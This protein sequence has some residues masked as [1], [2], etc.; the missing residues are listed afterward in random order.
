MSN[1]PSRSALAAALAIALGA[2]TTLAAAATNSLVAAE[3]S[4]AAI[5]SARANPH[6]LIL[7]AG[8]FDPATQ[9]LDVSQVGAAA[10]TS[11]SAYAIVQFQPGQISERKALAARG[12]TFLG[13]V[14]NQAYYARLDG[15]SLSELQRDPAVRWA[16]SVQPAMKLDPRL[17]ATQRAN[18]A[19][20]QDDGR[21]EVIIHGFNGVS[22]AKIQAQLLQQ[23]AGVEIT[24]RSQRDAATPYV[25]AR[26]AADSLDALLRAATA[27]DGVQFVMPWYPT[28][29]MNAGSIGAIQGDATTS[30]D[31][32]G[33]ICGPAPLFD[34][35]IVGA[36]QIIAIADTGTT[37][38]AAWFATLDKGNGPHTEVTFSDNPPPV[39]PNIG[40]LHP[41]NKII[42]YWLQPGG[43]TDYDFI[44]G[45]G[46]HTTG[47]LVGDSAGAFATNSYLAATPLLAHHELADGMAPNAQLLMQDIGPDNDR[48]VI[49]Q[50]FEGTLEQAYA[51]GARVHSN[52]WGG[53]SSGEYSGDDA[54]V[55]RATRASE[56]LLVVIAAGNDQAGPMATSSPANSKNGIAVAALGHAGNLDQASFSNDG[57]TADGRQKPDIAAP[58]T[59]TISALNS[60]GPITSTVMPPQLAPDSGTSMAA[61]VIAGNAA[62]LREYFAD[63]FYPRGFRNQGAFADTIFANGFDAAP[64]QPAT[65][66]FVDA[67][68]PTGAVMKAV[69]L[70]G[71]R[72]TN[73]PA[74]WPN[75]GTGWG[76]PWLDGNLWFRDTMP[77][78]DDSRR[79]RVFE[80][81]NAAGLETGESNE[82]TIAQVAPG[83]EFRA[84][85]TWYDPPAAI[86]AAATLINNLDLEVVGPDGKTYLGN[87]FAD[88]VSVSGGSADAKD[89]VEQ[90]RFTTPIA[91]SYTIRVKATDVPGNG[92]VGSDRQGYGLAVSG[93]FGLPDP[94]A[95]AAPTAL[96]ITSN[97]N[98]GITIAA[99]AA[100]GATSF[101]LYR[102]DNATC[103]SAA[104]GAFHLVAN[105]AALPLTDDHSQGGYS[106][107]YKVRGVQNDVEGD[108]SACID[109]VSAAACTLQPSFDTHSLHAD[110]SNA[111]CSADLSWSAAQSNCPSSPAIGYSVQRDSDPYFSHPQTLVSALT[112]PNYTDAG[113]SNG[114]AYYYRVLASDAA[115]NAAPASVVLNVTPS[116]SD[117]PDPGNFLDDVDTHTY[118]A[119]EAPWQITNTAASAGSFSYHNS[120]DDQP[121]ADNVCAS[122]TTPVLT[123]TSGAALSWQARYD[124]EYQFDGV[125][126]EISTDGGTSWTDLPPDGGYPSTFAGTTAS[127]FNACGYAA[128]HG[129]FNGVTTAASNS[130]P[131]NGVAVAV[132]KPFTTSLA[133]YVGQTVQIRWRFSSDPATNFDGFFLDQVRISGSAGTGDHVCH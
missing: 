21:Y 104:A 49:T 16:G 110:A 11:E 37:P 82:Y 83:I 126:Q 39:L 91:G 35:G 13:Y 73:T 92:D 59:A 108:A 123:L 129:A 103:A 114:N 42:A 58:G 27:I 113:V 36:G 118:A 122:V 86:G 96:S 89:T 93:A 131:N 109:V 99:S 105:G 24:L 32:R 127:P 45:H 87:Q 44:S 128:S 62:L 25:R 28:H 84:T 2:T 66:E 34:H 38:N 61:P 17:W 67:Y 3:P 9:Q 133:A 111:S 94:L 78:G 124:L 41:D 55:D 72:P 100:A 12:V 106:Y 80:R 102:A 57:P 76:R 46:T 74:T 6:L 18:S 71:T 68:N 120:G 53:A 90:V 1:L 130:D 69:L 112:A 4:L 33:P 132:F 22:S 85:L 98:S 43:P 56:D 10:A 77:R 97:D 60:S 101:Q 7:R 54:N 119:L 20:L 5:D 23:V 115:G 65:A 31:G 50:D 47:T 52:S 48:N 40:L 26:V 14:P 95:F 117:G 79:L 8:T 125:V 116:G 29:T 107:A 63:G 121:Y 70:N 75:T 81:T 88:G 19:A 30:C 15:I 51:G 64:T